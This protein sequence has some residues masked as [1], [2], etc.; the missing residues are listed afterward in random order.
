MLFVK[1]HEKGGQQ[2]RTDQID[3][4]IF[5]ELTPVE[6]WLSNSDRPKADTNHF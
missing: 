5:V 4:S 3:T 6:D 1:N 2:S